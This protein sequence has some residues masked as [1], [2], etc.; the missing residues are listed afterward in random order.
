MLAAVCSSEQS[1]EEGRGLRREKPPTWLGEWRRTD[2]VDPHEILGRVAQ[3]RD[4][5]LVK[6]RNREMA[7][8]AFSFL[9]GA[10]PVM[11]ADLTGSLSESSGIELDVCGDAHLANFG[12]YYSPERTLVF[13][14]NDFDEARSGPWEW[15][16]CRLATSV[17]V[18]GR[19][20]LSASSRDLSNVAQGAVGAY[21]DTLG[22]LANLPLI[23]RCYTATRISAANGR[24][25]GD[26]TTRIRRNWAP[27]F[28]AVRIQ[29]QRD[30]VERFIADH[31]KGA[32]F[33]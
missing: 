19:E 4:P 5:H 7:A 2:D 11:S 25:G 30:T 18:A 29:T 3:G 13:D 22:R 20:F 28:G 26:S 8:S 12:V 15:D 17:V 23:E 33:V 9:R 14:V 31:G 27:L 16:V 1:V 6:L 24:N 21:A 10:A 32:S